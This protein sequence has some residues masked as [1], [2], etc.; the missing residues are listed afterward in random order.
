MPDIPEWTRDTRKRADWAFAQAQPRDDC[1]P[2]QDPINVRTLFTPNAPQEGAYITVMHTPASH[3]GTDDIDI[4]TAAFSRIETFPVVQGFASNSPLVSRIAASRHSN[5]GDEPISI[6]GT[7][8]MPSAYRSEAGH[9][10]E[11]EDDGRFEFVTGGTVTEDTV[12]CDYSDMDVVSGRWVGSEQGDA[13]T[14]TM[15]MRD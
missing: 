6:M 1:F 3:D 5:L 2:Q 13:I 4:I 12:V 15:S 7:A 11:A 10:E 8:R 9:Q 14:E